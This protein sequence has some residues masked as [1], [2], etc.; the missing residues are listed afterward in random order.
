M[1]IIDTVTNLFHSKPD[2]DALSK[3]TVPQLKARAK[4]LGIKGFDGLKKADLIQ[5]ILGH[6]GAPIDK[7]KV[8]QALADAKA[9]K[10]DSSSSSVKSDYASHPKF[11]KFNPSQGAE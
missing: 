1:S 8:D 3:E 7:E 4:E 9:E 2:A 11:A 5:A 6:D 10:E